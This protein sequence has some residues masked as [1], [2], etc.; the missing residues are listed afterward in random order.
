MLRAGAASV[1][2]I[3]EVGRGAVC[4]SVAVGVVVVTPATKPA[5]RG[6]RDSKLMTPARRLALVPHIKRWAD[7]AVGMATA[8][9]ID[10]IGIIAA[11]RLAAHR[12]L[13]G[14]P[15]SPQA[16]LLDG[17]HDYLSA[18]QQSSLFEDEA[19]LPVVPPVTTLVKADLRCAGVAAASILAKVARDQQMIDLH[20]EFP[21][22]GLAANKGYGTPD[23]LQALVRC[24]PSPHH[25]MSW[26]LPRRADDLA[27]L[28]PAH[29]FSASQAVASSTATPPTR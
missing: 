28:A 7:H 6:V 1:A 29:T 27:E 11:M 23:H 20:E 5:P 8:Q 12:A 25:R 3:D 15:V 16:V 22:Y 13:F 14:L 19:A 21:Q 4:G 17:A 26:D 24:G 10:R 2:C 9:E 18:P